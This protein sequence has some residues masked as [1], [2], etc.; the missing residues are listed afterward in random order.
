MTR[1]II[2]LAAE[3][4]APYVPHLEP[5]WEV[6]AEASPEGSITQAR[7]AG[8]RY[9]IRQDLAQTPHTHLPILDCTVEADT[10]VW[11]NGRDI[12]LRAIVSE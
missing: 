2:L 6:A 10:V 1:Y 3:D 9:L 8:D 12:V 5:V 11:R 7:N 4:V